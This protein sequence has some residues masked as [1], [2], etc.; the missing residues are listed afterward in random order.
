MRIEQLYIVEGVDA[1]TLIAPVSVVHA[2]K[3]GVLLAP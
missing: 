1:L 2:D 3:S